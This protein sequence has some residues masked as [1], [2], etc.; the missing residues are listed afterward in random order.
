MV[1][2]VN[3][4]HFADLLTL[5]F[6]ATIYGKV[7]RAI[8]IITQLM[9]LFSHFILDFSIFWI[10]RSLPRENRHSQSRNKCGEVYCQ[11]LMKATSHYNLEDGLSQFPLGYTIS[12]A[13]WSQI[14][15]WRYLEELH[16]PSAPNPRCLLHPSTCHKSYRLSSLSATYSC[17]WR[18]KWVTSLVLCNLCFRAQT[19][20]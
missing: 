20:M 12:H 10:Y 19:I 1:T 3:S 5:L 17:F 18:I 6:H 7:M 11:T 9:Q 2:K 16:K 15:T 14:P 13:P 4:S 8:L